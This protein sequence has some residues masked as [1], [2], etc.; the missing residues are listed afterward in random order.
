MFGSKNKTHFSKWDKD[1]NLRCKKVIPKQQIPV[2]VKVWNEIKQMGGS[3]R[4]D[5]DT[6][7]FSRHVVECLVCKEFLTTDSAR[8]ILAYHKKLKGGAKK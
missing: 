5:E 1:S 3:F 2:F 8:K 7:G 6:R 4:S